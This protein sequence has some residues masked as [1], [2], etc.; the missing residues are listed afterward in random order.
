MVTSFLSVR[1]LEKGLVLSMGGPKKV[2]H[3]TPV[4]LLVTNRFHWSHKFSIRSWKYL[5]EDK[6][7]FQRLRKT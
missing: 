4:D 5:F 2:F 1:D 6:Y 7:M 3:W